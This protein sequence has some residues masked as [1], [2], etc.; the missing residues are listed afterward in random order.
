MWTPTGCVQ[1]NPALCNHLSPILLGYQLQEA[2]SYVLP[3]TLPR[4]RGRV[5]A[6]E[7]AA[8]MN[9]PEWWGWEDSVCSS[10]RLPCGMLTT[11]RSLQGG[12]WHPGP[13]WERWG[14]PVYHQFSLTQFSI[15]LALRSSPFCSR[16]PTPP[17]V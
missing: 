2:T 3:G 10:D 16:S 1:P 6:R 4:A 17:A 5:S 8:Q 12:P 9:A 11:T 7:T 15:F 13:P 14:G